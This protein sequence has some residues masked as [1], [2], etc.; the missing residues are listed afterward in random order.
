M[1][2]VY[3]KEK[4]TM[5]H[6]KYVSKNKIAPQKKEIIELIHLVQNEVRNCFTFQYEF[7][8]SVKKIW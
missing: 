3:E 2:L 7:I 4:K 1:D 5:F 8:G 6:Y